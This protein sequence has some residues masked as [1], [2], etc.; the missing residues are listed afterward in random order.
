MPHVGCCWYRHLTCPVIQSSLELIT[1]SLGRRRRPRWARL[2][3]LDD[4]MCAWR[5]G[6]GGGLAIGDVSERGGHVTCAVSPAAVAVCPRLALRQLI[7]GVN[8]KR[9]RN[10]VF[11]PSAVGPL[12]DTAIRPSV[13]P[14]LGCRHAGCLQLAGHQ[15][16]ADCGPV[17]GRTSIRRE[18]NCHRRGH[19][20]YR[21][22]Y[23]FYYLSSP[24]QSRRQE[25]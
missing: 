23:Y 2:P 25:N 19:D 20:Y 15:R 22:Y 24:A 4:V 17:R 10:N 5:N 3:G 7:Q 18:S 6:G 1:Q 11:M 13:C 8:A 14:S 21:Y 16:C 12:S 9:W